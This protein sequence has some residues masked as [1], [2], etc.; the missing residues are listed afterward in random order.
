[1]PCLYYVHVHN[2]APG[3][4]SDS[5]GDANDEI[6]ISI[7]GYGKFI[8]MLQFFFCRPCLIFLPKFCDFQEYDVEQEYTNRNKASQSTK[9]LNLPFAVML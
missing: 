7:F 6:P 9:F 1:M 4:R 2:L 8:V 5:S 3:H